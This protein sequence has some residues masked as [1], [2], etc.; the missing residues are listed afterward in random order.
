[1]GHRSRVQ[2]GDRRWEGWLRWASGF[3][4]IVPKRARKPN[5]GSLWEKYPD[6]RLGF[7]WIAQDLLQR[8]CD[9]EGVHWVEEKGTA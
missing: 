8:Q 6:W 4:W 9:W 3:E 2:Q 5:M 7:A 1:M